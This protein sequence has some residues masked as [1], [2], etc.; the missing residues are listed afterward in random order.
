MAASG[1]IVLSTQAL[2]PATE[3][4]MNMAA[5]TARHAATAEAQARN[6]RANARS[7]RAMAEA[8][9]AR[10]DREGHARWMRQAAQCDRWAA[11]CESSAE[12]FRA[13]KRRVEVLA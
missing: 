3:D 11:D 9:L 6:W 5:F 2:Q 13:L 7:D 10:G 1:A 12:D 8:C 4:S